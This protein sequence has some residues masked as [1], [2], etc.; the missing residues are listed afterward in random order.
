M[1]YQIVDPE[2]KLAALE[3]FAY[4]SWRLKMVDFEYDPSDGEIRPTLDFP[5]EDGTVTLRQLQRSVTII[6]RILDQFHDTIVQIIDNKEFDENLFDSKISEDLQKGSTDTDSEDADDTEDGNL[7]IGT[8]REQIHSLTELLESIDESD[9]ETI[10]KDDPA[11][12]TNSED[13]H[14]D[15]DPDDDDFEFV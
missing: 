8:L 12:T 15:D 4:L 3:S 6:P 10:E 7:D 9:D 13:E 2:S 11:E 5:I 1:A 14:P